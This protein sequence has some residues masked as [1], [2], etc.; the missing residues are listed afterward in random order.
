MARPKRTCTIDECG[1]PHVGRGW[2]R[3]HYYRWKRHGD[4]LKVVRNISGIVGDD[5]ARFWHFVDKDGPGGCWLWTGELNPAGYGAIGVN[6]RMVGAHRFAYELLVGPI[7]EGLHLDH[8]WKRGCRH[9]NCVNP[10]HLEPVTP[11]ENAHRIAD[12]NIEC[13]QGHRYDEFNT[14]ERPDGKGKECLICRRAR[15]LERQRRVRAENLAKGLT[16]KGT[17]RK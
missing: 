7:P 14:Y 1:L 8:V 13:P 3:K 2:C 10:A 9:H 6:G 4:P 11:S 15:A 12:A 5:E 16:T 17:V